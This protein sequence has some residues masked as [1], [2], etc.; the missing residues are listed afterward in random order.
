MTIPGNRL[1]SYH[2]L[3]YMRIPIKCEN[4]HKFVVKTIPWV[5]PTIDICMFCNTD[6]I[7]IDIEQASS[8]N[9]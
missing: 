3:S 2:G 5:K 7:Y 4:G 1:D 6:Q 8:R 9:T